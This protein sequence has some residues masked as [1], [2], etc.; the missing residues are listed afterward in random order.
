MINNRCPLCTQWQRKKIKLL[1][2]FGV[3][4]GLVANQTKV[5]SPGVFIV[6]KVFGNRNRAP[7]SRALGYRSHDLISTTLHHIV[8]TLGAL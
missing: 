2:I 3:A 4:F 5:F 8:A 1:K 7:I 6:F